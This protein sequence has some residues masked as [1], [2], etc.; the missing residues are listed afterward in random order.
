MEDRRTFLKKS[1]IAAAALSTPAIP[2]CINISTIRAKVPMKTRETEKAL[3]LWYSQTGYTERNGKLLARTF[4]KKGIKVTASEI[5]D[6]NQ[7]GI[8]NYDLIVIGSP[9]FYYDT[10]GFVKDWIMSL[11]GLKGTPVASY[12]TFGGPE[13]NQRNA[14][15][16]ILECLTEKEGVPIGFNTF[17][18]MA[19]YPL[20]WSKEK[21]SDNVWMSRHLPNE[22]T[23]K[24]VRAYAGYL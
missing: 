8:E 17:M 20:S 12:V 7:N 16:S 10:P 18:N 11:P 14:A 9:V 24:K 6:F 5:R 2:G 23:Y 13:G 15:C 19:A 1:A 3:V 22:E 4:E 21:V